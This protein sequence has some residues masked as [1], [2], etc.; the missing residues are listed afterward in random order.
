MN[1]KYLIQVLLLF[2]CINNRAVAQTS[3]MER[4]D[5]YQLK[6][7]KIEDHRFTNVRHY[8]KEYGRDTI[9]L[10]DLR[11][12]WLVL[13]F[14]TRNCSPCIRSFPKLDTLQNKYAQQ[15]QVMLIGI[16]DQYNRNIES[17]Y[18]GVRLAQKLNLPIAYDTALVSK[19]RVAYASTTVFISPGGTLSEVV[20]G[21]DLTEALY[22]EIINRK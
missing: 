10:H 15:A 9:S 16:N 8:S 19:L 1:C 13:Y 20:L 22:R 4:Q 6:G 11:N 17:F 5:I 21:S 3:D 12:K 14:W 7:T 18:D 2:V